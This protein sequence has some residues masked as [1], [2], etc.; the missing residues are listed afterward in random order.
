MYFKI[1][2]VF[3]AVAFLSACQCGFTGCGSDSAAD[4]VVEG[5]Q[6]M[7][8]AMGAGAGDGAT[9]MSRMAEGFPQEDRVFYETNKYSLSAESQRI[10]EAHAEWLKAHQGVAVTVEGHCDE[11]GTREYNLGL[12]ERR[13]NAAKDY[14][15]SLGID[16]AR[17]SVIS[18]G[19][20]RPLVPG[21]TPDA[22]AKNRVSISVVR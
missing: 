4:V 19:K 9:E 8:G 22:W 14:L 12:G 21:S 18:Y 15:I 17:I 7:A 5:D 13:A 10:L 11:R 1:L 6:T 2:S 16:A 3:S 20:D